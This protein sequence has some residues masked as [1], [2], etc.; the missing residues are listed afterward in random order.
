MADKKPGKAQLP[1]TDL[2]RVL[3]MLAILFALLAAWLAWGGVQQWRDARGRRLTRPRFGAL[4]RGEPGHEAHNST[5]GGAAP[6][7]AADWA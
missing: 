6:V 7:Q 4:P 3:P 5:T 1:A 2:R